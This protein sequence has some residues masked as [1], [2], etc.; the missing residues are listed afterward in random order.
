MPAILDYSQSS[1]N[2][3]LRAIIQAPRGLS[4]D[5]SLTVEKIIADIRQ[6]GDKALL[7]Y[8]QKFDNKK[9]TLQSLRVTSDELDAAENALDNDL[10]SALQLAYDRISAFHQKLCPEHLYYIDETGTHL[11]MRYTPIEAAGVYIPGGAAN[12]PSSVLMN[13]IPAKIA[14]VSRIVA[15]VPSVQGNIHPLVLYALKLA[16]ADEI[17]KVGG[18][19]AIAALAYGTELIQPVH[20]I[21]GPGNAY[22]A[23]AKKQVFGQVGIDSIAGPSEILVIAD[24][25]AD[26]YHTAI[27]L[28]SQSEHDRSAQSILIATDTEFAQ[29]VEKHV[30]EILTTL[31]RKEIASKSW[32]D[33][34]VII[35]VE[36]LEQA[37]EIS[38]Q[39]APEHLQLSV[40]EP[41][42]LLPHIKHAGA[43]FMG[44][45]TPEAIGDY[46]AGPNHVLPTNGTPK[47]AS[48]LSIIDFMKR[49][50]LIQCT[51]KSIQ[52]IAPSAIKLAKAEG[53]DA[54]AMSCE[55]RVEE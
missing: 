41:E 12:Y 45:Y 26:P 46:I 18:A 8:T 47:F 31:P 42:I 28:L 17:Y 30:N 33:H 16:G 6:H 55:V 4:Q 29:T 10:K 50:S 9:A 52:Y 32:Q 25:G 2:H 38:N 34:G 48:G 1:F 21:T 40:A 14:G 5:V 53:L 36:T 44:Y 23:E 37:A 43:I 15:V 3:Q 39:F 11:G 54:H 13:I 20:K 7:E 27:D 35:H 49:T 24:R 19:Q 51:Q 22:V